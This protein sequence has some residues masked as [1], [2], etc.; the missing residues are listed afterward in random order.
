VSDSKVQAAGA[1]EALADA[2][3]VLEPELG[4]YEDTVADGDGVALEL[5]VIGA[6]TRTQ[7][8]NMREAVF[9]LSNTGSPPPLIHQANAMFCGRVRRWA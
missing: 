5:V 9:E 4:A 8:T 7:S 1:G 3:N 6:N 2:V